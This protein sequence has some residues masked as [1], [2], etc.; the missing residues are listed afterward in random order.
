M[1]DNISKKLSKLKI[2]NPSV[3]INAIFGEKSETTKIKGLLD[4]ENE[5]EFEE[6]WKILADNWKEKGKPGEEFLEYMVKYQ[7]DMIKTSMIASVREKCGLGKPPAEYTQNSNESINS[8]LKKSKGVGKLT[9]KG[10]VQ[11]IKSAVKMQEQKIKMALIGRGEW[12][13]APRH[14]QSGVSEEVYYKMKHEK[15]TQ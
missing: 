2:A 7:K 10:T 13:L 14:K 8:K 3:I 9:V 11:L 15:K 6:K 12:S 5:E 1:K 4:A